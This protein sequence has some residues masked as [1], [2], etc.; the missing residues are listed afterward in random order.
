[1]SRTLILLSKFTTFFVFTELNVLGL[2]AYKI[3]AKTLR[4]SDSQW[5]LYLCCFCGI[6]GFCLYLWV[7]LQML[8]DP[9]LSYFYDGVAYYTIFLRNICSFLLIVIFYA[10]QITNRKHIVDFLNDFHEAY[11]TF[12]LFYTANTPQLAIMGEGNPDTCREIRHVYSPVFWKGVVCHLVVIWVKILMGYYIHLS[13]PESSLPILLFYLLY[14]YTLQS[15]TSSYLL[16][17]TRNASFL[18]VAMAEKLGRIH[19]EVKQLAKDSEAT[20][21]IKMKRFCDLSDQVDSLAISFNRITR[22]GMTL[23]ETYYIHMLL[24][25]GYSV[26]NNLTLCF[27]LYLGVTSNVL[28]SRVFITQILFILLIMLEIHLIINSVTGAEALFRKVLRQVHL[29]NYWQRKFDCRLKLSVS[30]NI[31]LTD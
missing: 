15:A 17:S 27:Q 29:I 13:F 28:D 3:D 5:K 23:S 31:Q 12:A 22:I 16:F 2:F 14:P 10:Y 20:Q 19:E 24:I 4:A 8:A 6:S 9:S 1:M 7:A 21:F 30:E 26:S 11:S 18:Y 25:L